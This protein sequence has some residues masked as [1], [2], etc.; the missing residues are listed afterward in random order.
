MQGGIR[1]KKDL[2]PRYKKN[3]GF[4]NRNRS[5]LTT[6]MK[7]ILAYIGLL[8]IVYL[9]L[10]VAYSD[11]NKIPTYELE[12]LE[13][14]KTNNKNNNKNNNNN[15]NVKS[16]NEDTT[17][18]ELLKDIKQN[19]NNNIVDQISNNNKD[20]KNL[21]ERK[22]IAKDKFNNEVAM[23]QETKNLENDLKPH[24]DAKDIPNKGSG[25][26]VDE[27]AVRMAQKNLII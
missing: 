17:I 15:V 23:Q 12:R 14:D 19:D 8:C 13:N 21:D 22:K 25:S 18:D 26:V 11:L 7:K 4:N 3:G 10:R 27:S 9:V 16:N 24:V 6:P 1:R 2:L 20:P 5:Y